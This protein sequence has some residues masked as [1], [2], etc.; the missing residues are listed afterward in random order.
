MLIQTRCQYVFI[1]FHNRFINIFSGHKFAFHSLAQ[2]SSLNYLTNF[3]LFARKINKITK[4]YLELY[5][6]L[7][8][9]PMHSPL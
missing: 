5:Q 2:H 3:S 1:K 9:G 8:I 6:I 7:N 4:I